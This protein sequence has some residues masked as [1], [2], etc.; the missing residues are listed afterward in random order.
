MVMNAMGGI[1]EQVMNR[2]RQEQ[3]QQ[4]QPQ[5]QQPQP[6]GVEGGTPNDT[7]FAGRAAGISEM[8]TQGGSSFMGAVDTTANFGGG[9]AIQ[10]ANQRMNVNRFGFAQAGFEAQQQQEAADQAERDEMGAAVQDFMDFDPFTNEKLDEL[11]RLSFAENAD[12]AAAKFMDQMGGVGAALGAAG[13]SG[14]GMAA[15]MAA[16]AAHQRFQ[17]IV[18]GQRQAMADLSVRQM[19]MQSAKKM[20]EVE[21][22]SRYAQILGKDVPTMALETFQNLL[23]LDL[24]NLGIAVDY[25]ASQEA[26]DAQKEAGVMGMIGNIA[27][28]LIGG[29][30]PF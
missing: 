28:G 20:A 11:T 21:A 23:E 10:N 4:Q 27:G 8:L 13:I 15:G 5:G 16:Q 1:M 29:L 18:T 30:L 7:S 12:A 22:R 6:L 24:A 14:G 25:K 3:G 19:E 26:A 9:D 17:S 2:S